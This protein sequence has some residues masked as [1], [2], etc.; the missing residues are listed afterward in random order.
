MHSDPLVRVLA[1][2]NRT[3]PPTVYRTLNLDGAEDVELR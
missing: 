2:Q 1:R 3:G